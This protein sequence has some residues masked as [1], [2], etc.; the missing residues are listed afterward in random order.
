MAVSAVSEEICLEL[1]SYV[2]LRTTFLEFQS[3]HNISCFTCTPFPD[4][5]LKISRQSST[6]WS[7]CKCVLPFSLQRGGE[8]ERRNK[9]WLFVA[10]QLGSGATDPVPGVC[11]IVPGRLMFTA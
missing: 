10:A 11:W 1:Q 7:G 4:S 3:E 8:E 2:L 6:G 5:L 9:G